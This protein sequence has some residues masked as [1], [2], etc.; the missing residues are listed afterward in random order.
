MELIQTD[1]DSALLYAVSGFLAQDVEK[2]ATQ[3][4]YHFDGVHKPENDRDH[5]SLGYSQFVVPL[6]KAVQ[7]QQ[8]E[9]EK[10]KNDIELL[11]TRVA[12]LTKALQAWT[13][14]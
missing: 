3:L 6:V 5:Y 8:Q 13:D 10:Q 1:I 12:Q 11:K 4:G 2:A 14:K 9:I 7:E